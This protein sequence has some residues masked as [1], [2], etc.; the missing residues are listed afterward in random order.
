MAFF[1]PILTA[2]VEDGG[3]GWLRI[4]NRWQVRVTGNGLGASLDVSTAGARE[5]RYP[6]VWTDANTAEFVEELAW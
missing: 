5:R 6:I 2:Q 1:R 3:D 4:E